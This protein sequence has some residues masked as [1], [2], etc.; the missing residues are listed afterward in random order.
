MT[1]KTSLLEIYHMGNAHGKMV[2]WAAWSHRDRQVPS[3]PSVCHQDSAMQELHAWPSNSATRS[4]LRLF[5]S[6]GRKH[7]HN[8]YTAWVV[9]TGTEEPDTNP[10]PLQVE[11]S[12][13][14]AC[15]RQRTL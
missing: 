12:Y 6:H 7:G 13:W 5:T 14:P 4:P 10:L 9:S 2:M 3:K 15:W 1:A 8:T 11:F